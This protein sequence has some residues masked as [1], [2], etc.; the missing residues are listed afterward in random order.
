MRCE[1]WRGQ[2]TNLRGVPAAPSGQLVWLARVVLIKSCVAIGPHIPKAHL[3]LGRPDGRLDGVFVHPGPFGRGVEAKGKARAR[4]DGSR[5]TQHKRPAGLW[6]DI[7]RG[8]GGWLR[9]CV[10]ASP[11]DPFGDEEGKGPAGPGAEEA[12]VGEGKGR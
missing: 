11:R 1:L 10:S 4:A 6:L 8:G 5:S 12:P 3:P 2:K 7:Q 9:L